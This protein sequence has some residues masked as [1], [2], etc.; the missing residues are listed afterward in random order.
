MLAYI[1]KRELVACMFLK[2]SKKS[3]FTLLIRDKN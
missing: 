1:N 3:C 2:Y